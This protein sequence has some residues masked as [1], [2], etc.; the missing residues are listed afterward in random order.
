[1][2][3]LT[4]C[5]LAMLFCVALVCCALAAG[6][7]L[8][9]V[10]VYLEGDDGISF[11]EDCVDADEAGIY[12]T[13]ARGSAFKVSSISSRYYT[14]DSGWN[15]A[16]WTLTVDGEEYQIAEDETPLSFAFSVKLNSTYVLHANLKPATETD[17][18]L[19]G[20]EGITINTST[21]TGYIGEPFYIASQVP[22]TAYT[23]DT[24]YELS[25]WI[26]YVDGVQT[27]LTDGLYFTP[28]IGRTY[29]LKADIIVPV[30]ATVLL[31]TDEESSGRVTIYE[32]YASN[33][34]KVGTDFVL[35]GYMYD[36]NSDYVIDSWTLTIQGEEDYSDTISDGKFAVTTEDAVYILTP[37]TT[38]AD[39]RITLNDVDHATFERATISA[40]AGYTVTLSRVAELATVDEGY[41][42]TGWTISV[43]GSD[44]TH[45][46]TT[47]TV[48]SASYTYSFTPIIS[49]YYYVTV[50]KT[51]MTANDDKIT[52]GAITDSYTGQVKFYVGTDY[53]LPTEET[54][55][56]NLVTSYGSEYGIKEWFVYNGSTLV[57]TLSPADSMSLTAYASYTLVPNVQF[58]YTVDLSSYAVDDFEMEQIRVYEGDDFTT[59]AAEAEIISNLTGR[60]VKGWYLTDTDGSLV[61]A[62]GGTTGIYKCNIDIGTTDGYL[63]ICPVLSD[64]VYPTGVND[65]WL[66]ERAEGG[67]Q[68]TDHGGTTLGA[69]SNN[70]VWHYITDYYTYKQDENVAIYTIVNIGSLDGDRHELTSNYWFRINT[71]AGDA[72]VTLTASHYYDFSYSLIN[73]SNTAVTLS[74]YTCSNGF[75]GSSSTTNSITHSFASTQ[76]ITIAA[77]ATY[78]FVQSG[79]YESQSPVG[80]NNFLTVFQLDT[81]TNDFAMGIRI[82][83]AEH[84][85]TTSGKL[86]IDDSSEYFTL[87]GDWTTDESN[88]LKYTTITNGTTVSLSGTG[89]VAYTL[90]AGY[91]ITGW[92]LLNSD[93]SSTGYTYFVYGS[94]DTGTNA[95]TFTDSALYLKPIISATTS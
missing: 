43:N 29:V 34:V 1:M 77:G 40:Y 56:I 64:P 93:G 83:V 78:N 69:D 63:L 35:R 15:L 6:C 19:E 87:S 79:F 70:D 85:G 47:Y 53:D 74:V 81:S 61:T 42:I 23:L 22:N 24:D 38:Y 46:N 73:Y 66:N 86:Y 91:E 33:K 80:D 26:L 55:Y 65:M 45:D 18:T 41:E 20:G 68:V 14:L 58:Y 32:E 88:S 71:S 49:Q 76:H 50:T 75:M 84:S 17:I 39:I 62:L 37:N 2:K 59:P 7:T 72:G 95:F 48:G 10:K 16:G 94:D 27:D 11:N 28:E 90:T 92:E 31:Q 52:I 51:G 60:T 36:I 3:R 67:S 4:K 21:L 44:E 12:T 9:A 30:Y 13:A 8:T 5:I 25:G 57:T 89:N 54:S 82:G